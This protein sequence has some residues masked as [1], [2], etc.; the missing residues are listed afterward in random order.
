MD[1][2]MMDW[3]LTLDK[4]L[5]HANRLYP[6]KRITTMLP[7]GSLHRY[8]YGD[9]YKRTKRMAKALVQLGV[10]PGD[11]VGTFAWNSFE[12]LELYY[13]IPGAARSVTH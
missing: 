12:H 9:L 8:T 6:H 7:D 13:A 5:E 1:G 11:R 10:D 2:L 4:I 3:Q